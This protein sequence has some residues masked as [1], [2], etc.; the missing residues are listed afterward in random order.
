MSTSIPPLTHALRLLKIE[1]AHARDAKSGPKQSSV[2][3]PASIQ[4]A[5]NQSVATT[6]LRRLPA[7]LKAI[8][9]QNGSL[10]G[11]KALR[12][13]IEAV[14]LDELG[15]GLQLDPEFGDLVERTCQTLEQDTGTA[16]LLTEALKELEALV[17]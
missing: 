8:R 11:G 9:A 15:S 17:E 4:S 3:K 5:P 14:L 16:V 12:V 2:A 6:A 10:N 1:L 7:K 13:F